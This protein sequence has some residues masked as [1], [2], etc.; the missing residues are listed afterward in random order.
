MT[1]DVKKNR[2]Y[3]DNLNLTYCLTTEPT[4]AL[5]KLNSI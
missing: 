1:I 3:W 2:H 5:S 4:V